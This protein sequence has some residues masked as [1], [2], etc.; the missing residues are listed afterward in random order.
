MGVRKIIAAAVLLLFF[1]GG[2]ICAQVN[3]KAPDEFR[4]ADRWAFR[5]NVLGWAMTLP[6]ISAEFDLSPSPYNRMTLSLEAKYNWEAAHRVL[7]YHNFNL[8]S[9]SPE[10]RCY[11]RT[12]DSE[13]PRKYARREKGAFY[14]GLYLDSGTYTLKLSETGYQGLHLG[15]GMSF[16]YAMPVHQY[17]KGALDVEFGLSLGL[18]HVRADAFYLNSYSNTY[19]YDP[20]FSMD[21]HLVPYPVVSELSIAFIWRKT[22]I[23]YKYIKVNKAKALERAEKKEKRN[24]EKKN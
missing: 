16:G 11:F 21:F 7:P 5:T 8:L 6:N 9:V 1:G 18:T 4:G 20:E 13:D 17:R 10:L 14:L 3:R 22:S 15:A 23:K 12:P 24:A 2:C 19:D